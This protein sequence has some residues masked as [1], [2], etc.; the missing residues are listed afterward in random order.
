MGSICNLQTLFLGTQLEG[1]PWP[2]KS[3]RVALSKE[4]FGFTNTAQWR[5][6]GWCDYAGPYQD[7]IPWPE[8][9]AVLAKCPACRR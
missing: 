3:G 4:Q 7:A 9:Q 8:L 1:C 6:P 2:S 5:D